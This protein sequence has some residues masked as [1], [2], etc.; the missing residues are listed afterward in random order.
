MKDPVTFLRICKPLTPE[1]DDRKI[2]EK[3]SPIPIGINY[4]QYSKTISAYT[5]EQELLEFA[6]TLPPNKNRDAKVTT[7]ILCLHKQITSYS[8]LFFSLSLFLTKI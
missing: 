4:Q 8:H 1:E 3:M 6:R 2:M 5:Q 7:I